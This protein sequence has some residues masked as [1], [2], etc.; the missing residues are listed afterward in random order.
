MNAIE[1][2]RQYVRRHDKHLTWGD[3]YNAYIQGHK[4]AYIEK[5]H[6]KR[7]TPDMMPPPEIGNESVTMSVIAP[8]GDEIYY[9]YKEGFWRCAVYGDKCEPD[10]WMYPNPKPLNK[11]EE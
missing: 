11:L 1:K 4:D 8:N 6:E 3:V 7:F 9:D 5:E 2:A 10:F